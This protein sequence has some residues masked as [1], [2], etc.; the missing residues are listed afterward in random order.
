MFINF[1]IIILS[2]VGK[3]V[4]I[5]II[6]Y[7]VIMAMK[8]FMVI[9]ILFLLYRYPKR[10]QPFLD[11]FVVQVE[12]LPCVTFNHFETTKKRQILRSSDIQSVSFESI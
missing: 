8:N 3:L 12:D 4:I 2:K 6:I 9:I 10:R 5:I 1:F 11:L 7:L